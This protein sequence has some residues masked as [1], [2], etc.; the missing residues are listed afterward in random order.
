MVRRDKGNVRMGTKH[1]A[2]AIATAVVV[3]AGCSRQP[4]APGNGGDGGQVIPTECP[5]GQTLCGDTCADLKSSEEHCGSCGTS[6]GVGTACANSAC[7]PL[8]CASA[9]CAPDQVCANDR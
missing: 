6:C 5:S 2:A 3:L 8:D 1:F 7:Y 9:N 4:P